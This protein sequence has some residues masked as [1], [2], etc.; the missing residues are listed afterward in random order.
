MHLVLR[1]KSI[2]PPLWEE[3]GAQESHEMDGGVEAGPDWDMANQ[4]TPTISA[5]RGEPDNCGGTAAGG[6]AV[7]VDS[8]CGG[9]W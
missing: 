6:G 7:P 5:L 2:G 4:S 1:L 9:L 8:L 3:C